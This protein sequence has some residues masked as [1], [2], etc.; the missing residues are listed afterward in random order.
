LPPEPKSIR[1][2]YERHGAEQFYRQSGSSYRN[3]HEPQIV[4][5]LEEALQRWKLDTTNVLDL[6][7]GSGEITLALRDHGAR[8]ITG[9]DPYTFEAY[10]SRTGNPAEQSTFEQIAD[11]A[12]ADRKFSLIV[13]SFAMHLCEPSRLPG[14]ALQLSMISPALVILTPH[15]RPVLREAWGWKLVE[16]LRLARI[17]LRLYNSSMKTGNTT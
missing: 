9:I 3:P 12:L 10:E 17:R 8:Q 6:A 7:A 15:K 14:L 11:G 4:L 2:E 16:E 1:G 5:A 13:C